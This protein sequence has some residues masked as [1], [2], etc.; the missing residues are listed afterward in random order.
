MTSA[1]LTAN[2]SKSVT[3]RAATLLPSRCHNRGHKKGP[4]GKR[5]AGPF[6]SLSGHFAFPSRK[7]NQAIAFTLLVRREYL[8]A[9]VFL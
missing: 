4:A 8:R 9:T 2:R 1:I 7:A 3:Y 5:P 6:C